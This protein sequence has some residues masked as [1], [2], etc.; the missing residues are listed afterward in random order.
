MAEFMPLRHPE[1]VQKQQM[2]LPFAYPRPAP[3]HLAIAYDCDLAV[4]PCD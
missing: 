2:I 4:A 1:E 3:D